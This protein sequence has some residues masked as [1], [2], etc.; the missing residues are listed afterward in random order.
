MRRYFADFITQ[1]AE[2]DESIYLILNDVGYGLF[3]EFKEKY[4]SRIYN[5]GVMEQSMIGIAAGMALEGLKPWIY[6]ITPFV[7]ERP[8]EQIKVDVD[9]NKANVKIVGYADYPK[10][11]R[12]H[13]C[14]DIENLLKR[15]NNISGYYPHDKNST[16][17]SLSH[18]YLTDSPSIISL[19]KDKNED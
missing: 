19:K 5:F 6:G 3:D 2:E 14:E 7:L 8:Y 16:Y 13:Q 1:K 15:F 11:G 9:M 10:Q 4:P 17:Q 12:T 18:M